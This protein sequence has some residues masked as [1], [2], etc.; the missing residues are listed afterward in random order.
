MMRQTLALKAVGASALAALTL[1][2]CKPAPNPAQPNADQANA[3]TAGDPAAP[4]AAAFIATP[5]LSATVESPPRLVG[6]SPAVQAIDADLTLMDVGARETTAACEVGTFTR[7]ITQPMTGPGYAAYAFTDEWSCGGAHPSTTLTAITYDLFTGQRIDWT[8]ALPNWKLTTEPFEGMGKG[9][10]LNVHSQALTAWYVK[11]MLASPDKQW[12]AECRTVF[13]AGPLNNSGFKIW[14]DAAN[15]GIAVSPDLAHVVQA[16]G[17]TAYM[18][19]GDM[20]AAGV[21]A[22]MIAALTRAGDDH[23]WLPYQEGA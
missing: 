20:R 11:K 2:S 7:T 16:C 19:A 18:S 17:E 1:V 4:T 23:N 6:S 3:A 14:A 12:L 9:E 15:A 8:Q 13:D 5:D 10:V 21:S 22:N